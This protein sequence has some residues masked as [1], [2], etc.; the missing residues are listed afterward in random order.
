[1]KIVYKPGFLFFNAYIR[2]RNPQI[3]ERGT[4]WNWKDPVIDGLHYF[5][6][7]FTVDTD[8]T[9]RDDFKEIVSIAENVFG[10][11]ITAAV[12]NEKVDVDSWLKLAT[13]YI[14]KDLVKK[15]SKYIFESFGLSFDIPLV[16]VIPCYPER[17][18]K[19]S[20]ERFI[21]DTYTPRDVFVL[22]PPLYSSDR[23]NIVIPVPERK[24]TFPKNLYHFVLLHEILHAPF[25]YFYGFEVKDVDF[26]DHFP[27]HLMAPEIEFVSEVFSDLG[28]AEI[29]TKLGVLDEKSVEEI[30]NWMRRRIWWWN[31][32]YPLFKEIGFKTLCKIFNEVFVLFKQH[33]FLK[34]ERIKIKELTTKQLRGILTKKYKYRKRVAGM[35][36]EKLEEEVENRHWHRMVAFLFHKISEKRP[37]RLLKSA[38]AESDNKA[39]QK[40]VVT[41]ER[42]LGGTANFAQ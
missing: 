6:H 17:Y 16:I 14:P 8:K 35:D 31:E 29:L 37:L 21:T 7:Y 20:Y 4:T 12:F 41:I 33:A 22:F 23:H 40:A 38:A 27:G 39:L 3:V 26:S 1:M 25:K 15:Y 19:S 11:E 34:K 5:F 30:Y 36:K 24:M 9:F 18:E 2:E 13:E 28:S 42:I 32:L 10:K